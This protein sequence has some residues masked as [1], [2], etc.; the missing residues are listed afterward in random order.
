MKEHIFNEFEQHLIFD[1][2]PSLYFNE[3]MEE[4]FFINYPLDLMGVLKRTEQSPLHHPEGNVWNHTM[5]VIDKAAIEKEKSCDKRVFMWGSFLHDIGKGTATRIKNNK[6]VAYDHDK[7]GENLA[8]EFLKYYISDE[9][10]IYKVK[11]LVRWHMQPLFA[12]KHKEFLNIEGLKLET[13]YRE[14][15]LLSV[16]DRLGRKNLSHEKILKEKES[17]NEFLRVVEES[18]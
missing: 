4:N 16:C 13:D 5:L 18:R 6:I 14:I 1:N 2:R 7:Y 3:K 9:E 17:I 8:E 11:K 15:A 10:F 12:V